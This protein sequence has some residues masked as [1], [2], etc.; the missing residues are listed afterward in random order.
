MKRIT[1]FIRIFQISLAIAH[2]YSTAC[3]IL[4]Q[5]HGINTKEGER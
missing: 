5:S 4:G 2:K 3:C 1:Q